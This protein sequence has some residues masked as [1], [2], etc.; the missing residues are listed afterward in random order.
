MNEPIDE[1]W[2]E[3]SRKM[4]IS[5]WDV[6][7]RRGPGLFEEIKKLRA[8]IADLRK[9]L[10]VHLLPTGQVKDDAMLT[11]TTLYGIPFQLYHDFFS[12][13][14]KNS[15]EA[16]EK[17]LRELAEFKKFK[18]DSIVSSDQWKD[19]CLAAESACSTYLSMISKF[20]LMLSEE[21]RRCEE[22]MY[23]E[24]SLRRGIAE[25]H[26]SNRNCREHEAIVKAGAVRDRE[27]NVKLLAENVSYLNKN[28]VQQEII[29]KMGAR[30]EQLTVDLR[31]MNDAYT[32]A[33]RLGSD[34]AR[35]RDSFRMRIVSLRRAMFSIKNYAQKFIGEPDVTRRV[36]ATDA[37][38]MSRRFLARVIKHMK[39]L[40]L[41]E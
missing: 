4:F 31:R 1:N 16:A 21:S 32:L 6:I 19:R 35:E 30:Q 7:G 39:E 12:E 20:N 24:A 37:E 38:M 40:G 25:L 14:A 18:L 29:E 10:S 36:T 28:K 15:A 34:S 8:T 23:I 9:E 13:I 3:E 22:A 17:V 33:T 11:L 5:A 2:I 26:E 27:E 41:S